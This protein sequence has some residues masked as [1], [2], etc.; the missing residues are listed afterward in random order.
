MFVGSGHANVSRGQW[1]AL[2]G[3]C[4]ICNPVQPERWQALYQTQ[5]E[6]DLHP[7]DAVHDIFP[8]HAWRQQRAVQDP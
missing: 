5:L 8:S 4:S 6:P 7:S 1:G 3:N 2:S